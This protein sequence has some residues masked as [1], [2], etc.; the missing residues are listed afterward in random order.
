[1]ALALTNLFFGGSFWMESLLLS[2]SLSSLTFFSSGEYMTSSIDQMTPSIL[3]LA[4]LGGASV[5]H[6]L[7]CGYVSA[8]HLHAIDGEL[9]EVDIVSYIVPTM[10]SDLA[11]YLGVHDAWYR[12]WV[13]FILILFCYKI[14]CFFCFFCFFFLPPFL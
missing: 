12:R 8:Q 14:F 2:L 10:H 1:M 9:D 4:V 6:R 5:L 11:T 13:S 3:R 7:L